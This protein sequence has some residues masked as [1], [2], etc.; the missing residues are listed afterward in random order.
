M[1]IKTFTLIRIG[2][3]LIFLAQSITAF[4]NPSDFSELL[5]GSLV[6]HLL[7]VSVE[8]FVFFIGINDGIVALCLLFGFD[9]GLVTI[10]A[11]LW[12]VGVIITKGTSGAYLEA[13][14][15]LGFLFMAVD[16]IIVLKEKKQLAK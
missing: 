12:I 2:L 4:S 8:H 15:S 5:S 6:S 9:L 14:E 7:P 3:A 16:L 1:K 11:G 13:L 10:W